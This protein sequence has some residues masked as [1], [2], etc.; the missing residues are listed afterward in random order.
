MG[1]VRPTELLPAAGTVLKPG[2]RGT[3]QPDLQYVPERASCASLGAR[4]NVPVRF[5]ALFAL[6][7]EELR[8]FVYSVR[9]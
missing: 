1:R 2:Q 6:E 4:C 3:H 7:D 5:S 9:Y 8:A